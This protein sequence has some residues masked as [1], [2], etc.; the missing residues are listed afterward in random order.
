MLAKNYL[1]QYLN[2]YSVV[3]TL[4]K[5][6]GKSYERYLRNIDEMAEELEQKKIFHDSSNK[7]FVE[8]I[9]LEVTQ[10][11]NNEFSELEQTTKNRLSY[12]A[13]ALWLADCPLR[14][15]DL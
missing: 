14:F 10:R 9:T 11:I 4:E 12:Y 7:E 13:V 2:G 3:R 1:R 15:D 5:S 6:Y 8:K